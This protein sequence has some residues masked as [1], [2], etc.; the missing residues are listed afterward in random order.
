MDLVIEAFAAGEK[1]V[2]VYRSLREAIV[3]GRLPAGHR[4]PPTRAL[5][6]E[7]GVSRGSVATAYERLGAGGYLDGAG[8]VG[9]V[10]GRDRAAAKGAEDRGRPAAPPRRL[11]HRPRAH[12]RDRAG[13]A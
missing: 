1:T 4:L 3:D 8:R 5:A 7:L 10:R 2:A 11:G 6:A 9:D 13:A 12:K